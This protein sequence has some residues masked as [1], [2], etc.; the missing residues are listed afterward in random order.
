MGWGR[1]M[2]DEIAYPCDKTDCKWFVSVTVVKKE[3]FVVYHSGEI[4]TYN[5]CETCKHFNKFDMYSPK[6]KDSKKKNLI[7]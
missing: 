3:G 7:K 1:F 2:M 4:K 6:L 5:I